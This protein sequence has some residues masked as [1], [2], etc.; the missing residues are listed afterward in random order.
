MEAFMG[1]L[2]DKDLNKK[3]EGY[4]NSILISGDLVESTINY[5]YN[6]IDAVQSSP[7]FRSVLIGLIALFIV[8]GV[9]G[10]TLTVAWDESR[11]LAN[12]ALPPKPIGVIL[13]TT[14]AP[15]FLEVGFIGVLFEIISSLAKGEKPIVMKQDDAEGIGS[16]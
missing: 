3:Q 10:M 4:N 11:L 15:S 12:Q 16:H 6:V 2:E 14:L 9:W 1:Q 5:S 7:V 8:L 13:L